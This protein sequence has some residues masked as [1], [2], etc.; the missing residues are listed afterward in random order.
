MELVPEMELEARRERV[1]RERCGEP[2]AGWYPVRCRRALDHGTPH[3]GVRGLD[4]VVWRGRG[5]ANSAQTGPP[6]KC[7]CPPMPAPSV[8]LHRAGEI[9]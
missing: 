3:I 5:N 9:Y 4:L 7:W 1:W 8:F 2:C 6:V